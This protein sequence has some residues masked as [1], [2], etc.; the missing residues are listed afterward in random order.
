MSRPMISEA[1]IRGRTSRP[2]QLWDAA[3]AEAEVERTV[4][5]LPVV[6]QEGAREHQPHVHRSLGLRALNVDRETSIQTVHAGA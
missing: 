2:A 3:I 6:A 4:S 5:L 1:L